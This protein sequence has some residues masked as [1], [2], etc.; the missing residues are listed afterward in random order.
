[1]RDFTPNCQD[2]RH[3]IVV[4]AISR[5]YHANK[6]ANNKEQIYFLAKVSSVDMMY[7]KKRRQT[8]YFNRLLDNR[9]LQEN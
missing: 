5:K 4:R 7:E 9:P 1:M 6:Y 8:T 3:A 2:V